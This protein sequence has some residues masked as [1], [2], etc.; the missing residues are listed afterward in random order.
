MTEKYLGNS[1]ITNM[2]IGNT[3]INNQRKKSRD[4]LE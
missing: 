2:Y 1:Q 3:F 4:E